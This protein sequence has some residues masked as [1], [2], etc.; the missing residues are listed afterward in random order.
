MAMRGCFAKDRLAMTGKYFSSVLCE[1]ILVLIND[2]DCFVAENAPRND[3][4]SFEL[5][6]VFLVCVTIYDREVLAHG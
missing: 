1:A 5:S 4:Q 3:R 6:E 2:K